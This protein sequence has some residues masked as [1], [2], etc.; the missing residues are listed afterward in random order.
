MPAREGRVLKQ[1]LLTKILITLFALLVAVG[2]QF[3]PSLKSM[4]SIVLWLVVVAF[5]PWLLPLLAAMVKTVK[6]P[7]GVEIEFKDFVLKQ[8]Q[9]AKGAAANANRKA[10]LAIASSKPQS[11]AAA[12]GVQNLTGGNPREELNSLIGQYNHIRATQ[13]RSTKRTIDMTAVVS[14]MIACCHRMKEGEF[15]VLGSLTNPDRGVRL[16]AYVDLYANPKPELLSA[17]ATSV[18][19]PDNR[20]FGQYWGIQAIGSVMGVA[21][22]ESVPAEVF[23]TLKDFLN[24][25]DPATDRH[26]ALSTV[27]HDFQESL[28]PGGFAR[29]AAANA[30]IVK[31]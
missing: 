30:G 2:H 18:P 25:L 27:L 9:E 16:A 29:K 26:Y 11:A 15:D 24:K 10:D 19:N 3:L 5:L 6:A 20:P 4:D 23:T 14:K 7:G 8:T 13:S 1:D 31:S 12:P 22:P 28:S 21:A 17:L